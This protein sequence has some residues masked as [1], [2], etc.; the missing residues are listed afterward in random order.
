MNMFELIKLE[1]SHGKVLNS[2]EVMKV[3]KAELTLRLMPTPKDLDPA[4]LL[5]G[6]LLAKID[7]AGAIA[8][9][10]LAKG[11]V[12]TVA[13]DSIEFKRPVLLGDLLGFYT[14]IDQIGRTSITVSV[15]VYSENPTGPFTTEKVTGTTLTYV[16]IDR[17]GGKREL[18][19]VRV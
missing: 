10:R 5:G 7:S 4:G 13:V 17:D 2:A 3:T 18:V 9:T 1:Q 8:A 6:W 16:A 12:A 14:T 11:K 15:D 19:G